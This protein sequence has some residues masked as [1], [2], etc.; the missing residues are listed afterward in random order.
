MWKLS[1]S[2]LLLVAM[3]VFA[4]LESHTLTISATRRII[5]QPDQARLGL[6]VTSN[7]AVSLDQIVAALSGLSITSANLTGVSDFAAPQ[8]LQWTFSLAVPLSSLSGTIAALAKLRQA[9]AENNSGL[10]LTFSINGTQASAQ[11]QEAQPCSTSDLIA[12]ATSQAQ[13]LAAAA[14]LAAGPI[15]RLSN[16]PSIERYVAPDLGFYVIGGSFSDLLLGTP[17]TCSLVVEFQLL[18]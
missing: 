10:T 16:T 13:K 6:T 4:Q 12:D 3:P 8:T 2:I 18:P 9:I 1:C 15:L 7:A 14:G 11:L 17:V 5:P